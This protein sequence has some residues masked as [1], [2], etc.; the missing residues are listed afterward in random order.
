MMGV[1]AKIKINV[2]DIATSITEYLFVIVLVLNCNTIWTSYEETSLNKILKVLLVTVAVLYIFVQKNLTSNDA[3]RIFFAGILSIFY[4]LIYI[5]V[6]G[7]NTNSFLYFTIDVF[8]IYV[9]V[10][11]A[12]SKGRIYEV[13][14]KYENIVIIVAVVSLFF[15]L[16]GSTLGIIHSTGTV[17]STWTG[18][19]T[20]KTV[21]TYYNLYFE[22]QSLSGVIRNTAIFTE[23]PMCNFHLCIALLVE[24]FCKSKHS[25]FKCAI[26]IVTVLTTISTTGWCMLVIALFAKYVF[27]NNT[28]GLWKMVRLIIVPIALIIA[29]IVLQTLV[30]DKLETSSGSIRIDDFVAGFEAWKTNPIFGAGY[31]NSGYVKKFMSSFR[32]NNQG[33]SNSPMQILYQGGLMLAIPYIYFACK[34]VM[35][36]IRRKDMQW[37]L[38]FACFIFLFT[39]TITS[40]KFLTIFIFFIYDADK[41]MKTVKIR[42]AIERGK[43]EV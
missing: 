15:W 5:V 8:C 37:F 7:Y 33:F 38:F 34:W 14:Y 32:S 22:T 1:S 9:F 24:L 2:H 43:R 31:G 12:A 10:R 30:L 26:L 13:L 23:A 36:C 39:I 3:Y 21:P 20:V 40:Y 41:E 17:Y 11:F 28:K 19:D 25:K 27:S 18:N 29:S 4:F 6:V 16:F 42:G 35:T